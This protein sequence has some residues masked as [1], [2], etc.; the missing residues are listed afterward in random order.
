MSVQLTRAFYDGIRRVVSTTGV[1]LF[2]LLALYMVVFLASLNTLLADGLPSEASAQIGLT[3]PVSGTVASI[4]VVASL[5]FTP[6]YYIAAARALTRRRSAL[7]SFPSRLFTRRLIRATVWMILAGVVVMIAVTIGLVLFIIPGIFLSACFLFV[8]FGI[9]V[10]DRGPIGALR[11]SWGLARGN[12]LRLMGFV[13][14]V[15]VIGAIVGAAG[16]ILELADQPVLADVVTVLVNAVLFV[17]V[18]GIM[19]AMYLQVADENRL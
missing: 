14:V 19:A 5:L 8:I 2:A 16:A 11:R 3:L 9:A 1:V 18:Y 10:E 12:R 15:G 6:M 7:G 13:F 4:L 17:P